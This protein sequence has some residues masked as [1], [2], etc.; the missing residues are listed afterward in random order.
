M[1]WWLFIKSWFGVGLLMALLA[2]IIQ[3]KHNGSLREGVAYMLSSVLGLL[4]IPLLMYT[5]VVRFIR[6]ANAVA[7]LR[8]FA[9]I[10]VVQYAG[11]SVTNALYIN[12][13]LIFYGFDSQATVRLLEYVR[14][15]ENITY[16]QVFSDKVYPYLNQIP[17]EV[18][19]NAKIS[20]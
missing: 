8:S 3:P 20:R 18:L 9:S 5:Q 12:N 15:F 17:E 7:K 14:L 1:D 6:E 11:T 19:K 4:W 2:Y 13:A 16:M 10:M